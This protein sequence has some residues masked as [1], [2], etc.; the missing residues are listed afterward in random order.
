MDIHNFYICILNYIHP[1]KISNMKR[2]QE[3]TRPILVFHPL[4]EIESLTQTNCN[5]SLPM[6]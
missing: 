1:G 6:N 5:K 2:I 4:E 3:S